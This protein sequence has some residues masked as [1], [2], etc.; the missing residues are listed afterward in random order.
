MCVKFVE[1]ADIRSKVS[2]AAKVIEAAA[3]GRLTAN[4]FQNETA[5]LRKVQSVVMSALMFAIMRQIE[6]TMTVLSLAARLS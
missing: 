1:V 6:P 5:A 4:Y 3:A 2:E